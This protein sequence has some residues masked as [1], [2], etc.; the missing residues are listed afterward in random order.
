MTERAVRLFCAVHAPDKF[1]VQ[2][3]AVVI[4]Q[5]MYR[6]CL[7]MLRGRRFSKVVGHFGRIFDREG[8]IAHQ[9]LLVSEITRL[10]ALSCGIKIS[11]VYHLVL[12]QYT[13]LTDRQ[14]DGR[15]EL[16]QQ[17]HT[18]HYMQLHGKNH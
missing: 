8:G 5:N 3:S 14:T 6:T 17:Y 4:R 11:A 15:T 1:I 2:L 18:L 7:F 9:P 13:H 12:S 16:R 10:T